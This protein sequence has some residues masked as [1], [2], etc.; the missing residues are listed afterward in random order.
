MS[1]KTSWKGEFRFLKVE[2]KKFK[3]AELNFKP[4]KNDIFSYYSVLF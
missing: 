2:E 3:F 1:N 4:P